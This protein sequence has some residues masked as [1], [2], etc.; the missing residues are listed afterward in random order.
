MKFTYVYI[1][2][3]L[4][5]THFTLSHPLLLSA[6]PFPFSKESSFTLMLYVVVYTYLYL[7]V[8]VCICICACMYL[9]LD[10]AKKRKQI[11]LWSLVY[12]NLLDDSN[13]IPSLANDMNSF[14]F[15]AK[16]NNSPNIHITLSSF[17]HCRLFPHLGYCDYS[18]LGYAHICLVF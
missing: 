8:H 6:G 13:S 11:C 17:F 7:C 2:Y 1:T 10:F 3:L 16:E 14:F 12:I 18:N 15:M 5:F 9:K 4:I